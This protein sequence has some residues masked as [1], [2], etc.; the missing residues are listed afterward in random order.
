M[1]SQEELEYAFNLVELIAGHDRPVLLKLPTRQRFVV[2]NTIIKILGD[3]QWRTF[4]LSDLKRGLMRHF[5]ADAKPEFKSR[6]KREIEYLVTFL[7]DNKLIAPKNHAKCSQEEVSRLELDKLEKR[8]LEILGLELT[9][10]CNFSCPHCSP[11]SGKKPDNFFLN[12]ETVVDIIK[13]ANEVKL[14]EIVFTGGEPF[15]HKGICKIIK[16]LAEVEVPSVIT[17]NGSFLRT[18]HL[19]LLKKSKIRVRISLYGG[20]GYY[21]AYGAGR[22]THRRILNAIFLLKST[23]RDRFS[24][25][26]PVMS[27]NLNSYNGRTRFCERNKIVYQVN[28]ICPF[29][30]A[31]SAWDKLKLNKTVDKRI[32]EKYHLYALGQNRNYRRLHEEGAKQL[33]IFPCNLNQLNILSNQSITPCLSIRTGSLGTYKNN[34]SPEQLSDLFY[35][36]RYV[37]YQK[38]FAV[39]RRLICRDCEYKYDCGGGCPAKAKAYFGTFNAPDPQCEN[40]DILE[41]CRRVGIK[42]VCVDS[43]PGS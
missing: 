24:C 43:S 9:D 8:Q 12:T 39:N 23:L 27:H 4:H 19:E 34:E 32:R 5:E 31:L 21:E 20:P 7:I 36:A 22:R 11:D 26:I 28:V 18:E 13:W 14:R 2:D 1:P 40:H 6:S 41:I 17:T 25:V 16:S 33:H 3:F 15:S 10:Y 35:S 38:R 29:G 30:R 37:N 42:R